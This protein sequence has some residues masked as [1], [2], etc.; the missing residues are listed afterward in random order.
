MGYGLEGVAA[1]TV[2]G[3]TV[4]LLI[5]GLICW[6]LLDASVRPSRQRVFERA[7][8][9]RFANL[10]ADIMVR[11]FVLLFAFAYFTSQSAGFGETTLAANAVLM[12]FFFLAGYFLDGLATAAEQIV[13]RAIGANYR[14]AFWKGVRLTLFWNVAMAVSLALLMYF[15][16]ETAIRLITTLEPVRQVAYEFLPYAAWIAITGVL[17]FQMD[18]IFIGATWSREMSLMMVLSLIVY[19]VAWQLLE[20]YGNAGLWIALHV[21]LG[22]RGITL[23]ARL[24]V[25]ARQAFGY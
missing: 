15:I 25:K 18:G 10:N 14:P 5:G 3:E 24:P 20:P 22:V 23:S 13:G 7:A 1:A 8:L 12:N 2:V 6:R 16:G 4:A 9:W 11:S 19:L 21:F 17:A